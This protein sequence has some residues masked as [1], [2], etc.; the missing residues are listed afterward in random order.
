MKE[1][2]NKLNNLKKQYNQLED[3]LDTI[4][5]EMDEKRIE[6]LKEIIVY[7]T[8]KKDFKNY[9]LVHDCS[10][11]FEFNHS[12]TFQMEIVCFGKNIIEEMEEFEDLIATY[13]S[14]NYHFQIQI[15]DFAKFIA[16][17]YQFFISFKN[18]DVEKIKAFASE[19]NF[20]LKIITTPTLESVDE[21]IKRLEEIKNKLIFLEKMF[22]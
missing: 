1:L 12:E 11:D 8:S 3:Q 17:D 10:G 16:S 21:Q 9:C 22:N 18:F 7:M 13:V 19:F 20:N 6:A 2:K 14:E 15:N 4:D 5:K